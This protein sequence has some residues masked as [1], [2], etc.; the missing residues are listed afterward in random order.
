LLYD[1]LG[2]QGSEWQERLASTS[3]ELQVRAMELELEGI[4]KHE[5][6]AAAEL[7]RR[8]RFF[9]V[10]LDEGAT[11]LDAAPGP[12]AGVEE[13]PEQRLQTTDHFVRVG[14]W[15]IARKEL[16]VRLRLEMAGRFVSL[17]RDV[18]GLAAARA[19]QRQANN[20]SAAVEVREALLAQMGQAVSVSDASSGGA[21]ATAAPQP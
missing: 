3:D 2:V 4:A 12:D 7:V 16:L 20:C 14:I 6:P 5:V 18:G 11:G 21:G 10:L 9:T 13:T 1:S 19:R 8:S 17:G 15:D